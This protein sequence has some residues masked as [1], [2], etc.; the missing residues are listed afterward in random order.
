MS[1]SLIESTDNSL[2][3]SWSEE[4]KAA[5]YCLEYRKDVD[6]DN[7]DFELL[8]N[9]LT[10]AQARKRNLNAGAS[11]FFRVKALDSDG[12]EVSTWI[13][14]AQPFRVLQPDEGRDRMAAPKPLKLEMRFCL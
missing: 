6:N 13:T 9:K 3:V 2:T 7:S 4:K 12:N 10:S 8:S 14:H 5:H 1:I 11:Y